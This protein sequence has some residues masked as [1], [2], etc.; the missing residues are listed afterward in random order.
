VLFHAYEKPKKGQEGGANKPKYKYREWKEGLEVCTVE[1]L[2]PRGSKRNVL[3]VEN[4]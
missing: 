1:N 3:K 4:D 2:G